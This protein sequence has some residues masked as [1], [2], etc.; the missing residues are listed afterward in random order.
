M[1]LSR[2]IIGFLTSSRNLT[3]LLRGTCGAKD[4]L[5]ATS[6]R[7]KPDVS[8][9]FSWTD[10]RTGALGWGRVLWPVSH[11]KAKKIPTLTAEQLNF[12][13]MFG[14]SY[15]IYTLPLIGFQTDGEP[16]LIQWGSY[17]SDPVLATEF[18]AYLAPYASSAPSQLKVLRYNPLRRLLFSLNGQVVRLTKTP[19]PAA[20]F[21]LWEDFAKAELPVVPLLHANTAAP[22]SKLLN[23]KDGE[24]Y[25]A[26]ATASQSESFHR[27]AG[28]S[29]A[30]LHQINPTGYAGQTQELTQLLVANTPKILSQTDAHQ[31][32]LTPLAARGSALEKALE[33]QLPQLVAKVLPL[34]GPAVLSHGDASAD[35]LIVVSKLGGNE[36]YLNDF[37]RACLAPAA[38]DLGSYL[39]IHARGAAQQQA[40]LSGYQDI[41]GELPNSTQLRMGRLYGA[42]GRLANPLRTAQPDWETQITNQIHQLNQ[43]Y[44]HGH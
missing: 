43:E 11:S 2:E 41:A 33:T 18:A 44:S 25:L 13:Q 42:L 7:V 23:G 8:V 12:A 37:D 14:L 38:L 10:T 21:G 20:F 29:F 28:Q 26:G 36:I 24:K 1:K 6:L 19:K 30:R 34:T 9:I 17:A 15:E 16:L 35:Q 39:Q 32:I 22:V 4:S 31:R 3:A 27:Q 5:K 40:F